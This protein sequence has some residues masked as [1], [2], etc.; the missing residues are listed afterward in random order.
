MG[1]CAALRASEDGTRRPQRD[2]W[3]PAHLT[4]SGR[5]VHGRGTD[6]LTLGVAGNPGE[7]YSS[8]PHCHGPAFGGP[9]QVSLQRVAGQW[10]GR[11]GSG[12]AE[13][14]GVLGPCAVRTCLPPHLTPTPQE[15]GRAEA[16]METGARFSTY[17]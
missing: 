14:P 4:S 12:A 1:S 8:K 5:P 7:T 6:E 16:R 10:R 9:T 17:W 2:Q 11:D 3:H 15:A 13:I